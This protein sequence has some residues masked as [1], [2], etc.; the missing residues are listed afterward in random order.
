MGR[1][2]GLCISV[3]SGTDLVLTT[4]PNCRRGDLGVRRYV[5]TPYRSRV[6]GFAPYRAENVCCLE[7]ARLFLMGVRPDLDC[8]PDRKNMITLDGQ[9]L[10]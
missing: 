6:I 9:T 7:K 2:A 10:F 8:V 1:H 3:T 4:A 5:K